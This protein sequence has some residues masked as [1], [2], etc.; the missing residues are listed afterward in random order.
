MVAAEERGEREV[1]R[2]QRRDEMVVREGPRV[3]YRMGVGMR[4]PCVLL[5]RLG[6]YASAVSGIFTL[7]CRRW[8][9]I[10]KNGAVR[11]GFN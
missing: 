7:V 6:R 10:P 3:E 4:R 1:K 5:V 2:Q 8:P 11:I 9:A